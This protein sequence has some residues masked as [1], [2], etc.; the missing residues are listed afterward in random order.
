V[1]V[2][3]LEAPG[4]KSAP[5]VVEPDRPGL[6]IPIRVERRVRQG[7]GRNEMEQIT[8]KTGTGHRLLGAAVA[9]VLMATGLVTVVAPAA[10]AYDRNNCSSGM[11]SDVDQFKIDTGGSG[12]VDFGDDAH[13]GGV[14]QGRAVVCWGNGGSS[15]SLTGKLFWD[16][17]DPGCADADV[18]IVRRDGTVGSFQEYGE[19]CSNGGLKSRVVES[20]LFS[21]AANLSHVRL[22]LFRRDLRNA[23]TSVGT[24]NI[25]FGD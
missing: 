12:D 15:V 10:H 14:P 19:I 23:R 1:F 2:T 24:F 20:S 11:R 22:R 21:N 16:S 8:G 3:G 9:A 7:E 5:L 13:I 6:R 25:R 17:F 18:A 4:L